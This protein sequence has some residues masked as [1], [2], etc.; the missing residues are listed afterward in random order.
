[1]YSEKFLKISIKLLR[2]PFSVML[3]TCFTRRALRGHWDT[4][5]TL[6]RHSKG[7]ETLEG[8]SEGNPQALQGHSGNQRNRT[9]EHLRHSNGTQTLGDSRHL[10]TR[11][12]KILRHLATLALGH[13][14]GTWALRDSSTRGIGHARHFIQQTLP[15][16]TFESFSLS[17]LLFQF[18]NNT[19]LSW[20]S[21]PSR[22]LLTPV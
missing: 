4:Q 12:L 13:L 9:L 21:Q 16:C 17:D 3:Q 5:R 8:H 6:R 20:L 19:L 15:R 7:T 10:S 14:K 2:S 22:Y 11:A 18:S 1:M